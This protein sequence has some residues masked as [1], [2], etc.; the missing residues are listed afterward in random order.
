VIS[1]KKEEKVLALLFEVLRELVK[2]RGGGWACVDGVCTPLGGIY[3]KIGF[4]HRL[5]F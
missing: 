4:F 1:T 5:N 2:G 3:K